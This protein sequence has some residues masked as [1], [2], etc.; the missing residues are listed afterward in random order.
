MLRTMQAQANFEQELLVPI[1]Y[2]HSR[3]HTCAHTQQNQSNF[4]VTF[5]CYSMLIDM[6]LKEFDSFILTTLHGAKCG[7]PFAIVR[8]T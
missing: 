2:S 6:F 1:V 5:V 7:E 3:A 4:V 8:Q